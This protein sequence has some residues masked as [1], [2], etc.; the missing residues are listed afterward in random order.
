[1]R[2]INS[3][4]DRIVARIAGGNAM[5]EHRALRDWNVVVGKVVAQVSVP[6]RVVKGTLY[7]SVKNSTWRQ[8][9]SM[10]KPQILKK[11]EEKFGAGI[12]RDIHF[13]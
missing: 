11:Y 3:A 9:L 13:Q 8:E 1:M 2:K 12:I 6:V 5:L 4:I 7:V 10:L